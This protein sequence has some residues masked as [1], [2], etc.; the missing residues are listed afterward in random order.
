VITTLLAAG[1]NAQ[2]KKI[3]EKT[4]HNKNLRGTDVLKQ[5]EEISK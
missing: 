1:A 4:S 3:L 5:L 2:A